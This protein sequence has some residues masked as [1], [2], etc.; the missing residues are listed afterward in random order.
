MCL[1]SLQIRAV[2]LCSIRYLAVIKTFQWG[3]AEAQNTVCIFYFRGPII[4][5]TMSYESLGS[6]G[7]SARGSSSIWVY[8]ACSQPQSLLPGVG[9]GRDLCRCRETYVRI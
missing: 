5:Y 6:R 7:F 1:P 2:Q 9:V 3:D 8:T 4:S